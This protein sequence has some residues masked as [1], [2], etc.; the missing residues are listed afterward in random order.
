MNFRNIINT[1]VK[2]ILSG[3]GLKMIVGVCLLTISG[4]FA[5]AADQKSIGKAA[6]GLKMRSIGPALMGGRIADIA[7][8]P[9]N[10]STWYVASASGG[11]CG[12]LLTPELR[13]QRCLTARGPIQ[14]VM[15]RSTPMIQM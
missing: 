15:F 5:V 13:G 9:T 10:G 12:K 14:L 2:N 8:H 11:V 4:Q 1:P 3:L 6:S 7:V